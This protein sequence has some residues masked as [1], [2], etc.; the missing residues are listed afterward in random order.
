MITILS[1]KAL[2]RI[3]GEDAEIFL[4]K[5]LTMDVSLDIPL[6]YGLLLSPKGRIVCDVFVYAH[7]QAFF[8][9]CDRNV[10]ER[11]VNLLLLYKL[12]SRVMVQRV[13]D[14]VVCVG[15]G[16]DTAPREGF[17]EDPRLPE[18]GYRGVFSQDSCPNSTYDFDAYAYHRYFYGIAEGSLDIE[19]DKAIPLEYNFDYLHA[20]SWTK[21][22]YVG[23]ELTARTKFVG[24]IRKRVFPYVLVDHFTPAVGETLSYKNREVAEVIASI[25]DR[26]LLL[27]RFGEV[28][29]EEGKPL[30][31]ESASGGACEVTYP[32]WL[33]QHLHFYTDEKK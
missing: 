21:G 27:L 18:L 24:A 10:V 7:D 33:V 29:Y 20:I 5:I 19:P 23:Q 1:N 11:F 31:L 26:G 15:W 8:I 6:V 17:F 22:C 9:E 2:I 16:D 28:P 30:I 32:K 4:Q 14:H 3:D 12:R 13:D 25:D